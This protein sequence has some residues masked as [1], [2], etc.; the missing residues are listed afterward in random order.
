MNP[1]DIELIIRQVLDQ[2]VPLDWTDIRVYAVVMVT[3]LLGSGIGAWV[4]A[5]FSKRGELRAIETKFDSLVSQVARIT[6]VQE[7]IRAKISTEAWVEQKQWDLKRDLYSDL[8]EALYYTRHIADR[9]FD[10]DQKRIW[11]DDDEQQQQRRNLIKQEGDKEA[12]YLQKIIKCRAIGDLV[13]TSDVINTLDKLQDAWVKANDADN[14]MAHVE[15][16]LTASKEAYDG[17]VILAREDL[18]IG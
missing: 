1:Q 6:T 13:L 4:G 2:G 10:I 8:L 11:A 17:L 7:E 18:R 15:E 16:R 5:F 3:T 12:P 14:F 9:I